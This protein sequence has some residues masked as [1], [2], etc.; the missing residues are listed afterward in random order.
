MNKL[1]PEL[2]RKGGDQ[3]GFEEDGE[4]EGS[5]PSRSLEVHGGRGSR[6]AHRA[7]QCYFQDRQDAQRVEGQ[8]NHPIV[9]KQRGYPR[10][11]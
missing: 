8:H 1:I 10:L 9:Q 11:Q 5:M 3:G 4:W 7:F 2:K 6:V